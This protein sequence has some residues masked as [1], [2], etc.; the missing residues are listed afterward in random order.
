MIVKMKS[1][2]TKIRLLKAQTTNESLLKEDEKILKSTFN[3]E[4]DEKSDTEKVV[5]FD[6]KK[7]YE[8]VRALEY[9]LLMSS[10]SEVDAETAFHIQ[11]LIRMND[12]HKAD[13]DQ[14]NEQISCKICSQEAEDQ[15]ERLKNFD[16]KKITST[17]HKTLTAKQQFKVHK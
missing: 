9:A 15:D 5:A 6:K 11:L 1:L 7:N 2:I 17:F 12:Q 8:L 14:N 16:T 4:N 10:F 13:L 3:S